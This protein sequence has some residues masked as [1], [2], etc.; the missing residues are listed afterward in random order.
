VTLLRRIARRQEVNTLE[1]TKGD[2]LCRA[3]KFSDTSVVAA[4][5]G[6]LAVLKWLMMEFDTDDGV[7]GGRRSGQ[8]W[9]H[10]HTRMAPR[11]L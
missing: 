6:D 4:T 10:S 1:W 8:T 9:T 11:C 5:R 7:E 3:W 2:P